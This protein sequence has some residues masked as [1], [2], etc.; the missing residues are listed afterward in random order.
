[1][2][3]TFPETPREQTFQTLQNFLLTPSSTGKNQIEQF[4]AWLEDAGNQRLLR[5][6]MVDRF[7]ASRDLSAFS[8][9]RDQLLRSLTEVVEQEREV[10]LRRERDL[11]ATLDALYKRVEVARG[12][13]VA[14]KP[15]KTDEDKLALLNRLDLEATRGVQ[16]WLQKKTVRRILFWYGHINYR[17]QKQLAPKLRSNEWKH[18]LVPEVVKRMVPLAA[19]T[20]DVRKQAE[21]RRLL[22]EFRE[23]ANVFRRL[24]DSIPL[25]L[26][27]LKEPLRS[28]Q[29][30]I[31]ATA[32][33]KGQDGK[34]EW[35][36][37]KYPI[38]DELARIAK[39]VEGLRAADLA[40]RLRQLIERALDEAAAELTRLAR[41][42]PFEQDIKGLLSR[43]PSAYLFA[44]RPTSEKLGEIW[45]LLT[46][47]ER[48][49]ATAALALEAERHAQ[50][51]E[52]LGRWK[53]S[54]KRELEAKKQACEYAL[55]L[56]L[57]HDIHLA[58]IDNALARAQFAIGRKALSEDARARIAAA[59]QNMRE[60]VL[61]SSAKASILMMIGAE[62]ASEEEIHSRNALAEIERNAETIRSVREIATELP[63]A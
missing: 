55:S 57:L 1:M 45:P 33:R 14:A 59:I 11:T 13:A 35:D 23:Q 28:A 10:R 51:L 22:A 43:E 4:V 15:K 34:Y 52:K 39:L 38:P 48:N 5:D 37:G 54:Q 17:D 18:D 47:Q 26:I 24:R 42:V 12:D 8:A 53:A 2:P 31:E 61:P 40:P 50:G 27:N 6:W 36:D 49:A 58:H 3:P 44:H 46:E 7:Q 20:S 21:R 25:R 16:R 9:W 29:R 41:R 30:V 56:I 60:D 19:T 32:V 62:R 63:E